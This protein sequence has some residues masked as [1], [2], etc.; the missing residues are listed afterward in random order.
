MSGSRIYK[1]A[2]AMVA[3]GMAA[4][5]VRPSGAEEVKGPKTPLDLALE[6]VAKG[7]VR[8]KVILGTPAPA[9]AYPFQVSVV[10]AGMKRGHELDAHYCG[11]TFISPTWVLTA[12]HCVT[13][14]G[15]VASPKI[16]EVL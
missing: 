9:D 3:A 2:L 6:R 8:E 12:G 15:A 11:G 4:V 16:F 7:K 10:L 13:H 5:L 1:A 14:D